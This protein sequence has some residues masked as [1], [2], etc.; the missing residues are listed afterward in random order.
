MVE[1][2]YIA[3]LEMENQTPDSFEM[4]R[5]PGIGMDQARPIRPLKKAQEPADDKGSRA[6]MPG[7]VSKLN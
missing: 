2:A 3:S 4:P 5:F 6:L 7:S 1:G